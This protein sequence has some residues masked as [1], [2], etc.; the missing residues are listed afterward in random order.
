LNNRPIFDVNLQSYRYGISA[1][2]TIVLDMVLA[3]IPVGMWRDPD[4]VM[5]ASTYDGL[6]EISTLEDWVAF[7]R[8]VR[9]R[10]EMILERQ[11]EFLR[12][13]PMITDP[14][15][16]YRRFARLIVAGLTGLPGTRSVGAG[17]TL[18]WIPRLATLS[19]DRLVETAQ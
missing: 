12:R 11:R 14:P 2:S 9:L 7:E 15:E 17:S 18:H 1:P 19:G 16:I 4:G 10:P 6:T 13:L 5:D 3:G 8:D